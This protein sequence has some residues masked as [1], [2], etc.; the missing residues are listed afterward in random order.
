VK[1]LKKRINKKKEEKIKMQIKVKENGYL[2]KSTLI[3]VQQN[4]NKKRRN[5]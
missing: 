1:K 4:I 3:K 5:K 2:T